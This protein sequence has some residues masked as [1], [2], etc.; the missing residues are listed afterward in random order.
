LPQLWRENQRLGLTLAKIVAKGRSTHAARKSEAVSDDI[1]WR[2]SEEL[3][4]A[5][6]EVRSMTE[7][8]SQPCMLASVSIQIRRESCYT[9]RRHV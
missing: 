2:K 1:L 3:P 9:M 4:E 5:V 6:S 7:A 8:D